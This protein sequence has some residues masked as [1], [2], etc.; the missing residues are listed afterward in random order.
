MVWIPFLGVGK[1]ILYLDWA[2]EVA[3]TKAK[4]PEYFNLEPVFIG[5]GT[6][7]VVGFLVPNKDKY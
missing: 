5:D 2:G 1:S 3:N 6:K 4:Q 7:V